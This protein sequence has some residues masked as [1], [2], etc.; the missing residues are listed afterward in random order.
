MLKSFILILFFLFSVSCG[1]SSAIDLKDPV[2]VAKCV[3]ESALK[4]QFD[5]MRSMTSSRLLSDIDKA[6]RK[7]QH[8]VEYFSRNGVDFY[9]DIKYDFSNVR[10]TLVYVKGDSAKVELTGT[11]DLLIPDEF[12]KTVVVNMS[13]SLVEVDHFYYFNG[14]SKGDI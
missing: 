11:Y 12:K 2:A 4:Y 6:E 14:W 3:Y 7:S 13:V 10:C 8:T 5:Y 1:Y 9:N